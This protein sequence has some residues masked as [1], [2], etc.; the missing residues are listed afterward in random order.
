MQGTQSL[1][2][3]F[4]DP[5]DFDAYVNAIAECFKSES[6]V[7]QFIKTG[8]YDYVC[9]LSEAYEEI[10]GKFPSDRLEYLFDKFIMTSYPEGVPTASPRYDAELDEGV[11]KVAVNA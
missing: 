9:N 5:I 3:M 10:V 6:E 11:Y 8:E 7:E 4:E 2:N 1:E